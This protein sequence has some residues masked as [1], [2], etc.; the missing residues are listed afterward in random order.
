MKKERELQVE[1]RVEG[2]W[3][4][5]HASAQPPSSDLGSTR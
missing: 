5:P 2:A 1:P 3:M 4:T